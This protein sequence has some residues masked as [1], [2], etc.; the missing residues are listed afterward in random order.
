MCSGK[1]DVRGLR[2]PPGRQSELVGFKLHFRLTP[3][4]QAELGSS[5]ELFLFCGG[6]GGLAPIEDGLANL[7]LLVQ[8]QRL[9]A[10]GGWEALL[11]SIRRECPHL[12]QRLGGAAARWEKPLALSAIP[13]GYVCAAADG[14][15]RL[16]DQAAV[17]PSFSGDGISIAL[18][19]ARG[20]GGLCRAW[21]RQRLSAPV[22]PRAA[23]PGDAGE[24]DFAGAGGRAG[25]ADGGSPAAAAAAA[26]RRQLDPH[27][28]RRNYLSQVA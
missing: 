18:H 17:I 3:A 11:A 5:V 7:C 13:Y 22:A 12:D 10:L 19:S 2:R 28:P 14:I 4:Q 9:Q 15:G 23:P 27:P 21:Q 20:R 26:P 1:H 6:Y 24:D 25:A 8:Q 16:G